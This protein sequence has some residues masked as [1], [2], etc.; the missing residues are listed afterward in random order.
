[1]TDDEKYR[2]LGEFKKE[3]LLKSFRA[4]MAEVEKK[5]AEWLNQQY[6]SNK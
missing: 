4:T 6:N 5:I 1:M 3:Q 2:Q